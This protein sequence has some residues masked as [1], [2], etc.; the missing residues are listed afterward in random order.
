MA[1]SVSGG[2][3]LGSG[4]SKGGSPTFALHTAFV[5]AEARP[6]NPPGSACSSVQHPLW[7]HV[8]GCLT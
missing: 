8:V 3:A 6:P 5:L 1:Y 2:Q 7:S 4:A